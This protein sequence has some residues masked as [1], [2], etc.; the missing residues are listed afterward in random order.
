MKR[1][2]TVWCA[3]WVSLVM[4]S[5]L[6]L[7][8]CEV[9]GTGPGPG[10]GECAGVGEDTVCVEGQEEV[11]YKTDLCGV[12]TTTKGLDQIKLIHLALVRASSSTHRARWIL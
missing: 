10:P 3:F 6:L 7:G 9:A 5:V 2:S 4:G 12:P 8:G 1:L 11:Y